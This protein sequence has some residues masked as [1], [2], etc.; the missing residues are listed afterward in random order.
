MINAKISFW[1]A[2]FFEIVIECAYFSFEYSNIAFDLDELLFCPLR[3]LI[4][5]L[6][7]GSWYFSYLVQ[8]IW[9]FLKLVVRNCRLWPRLCPNTVHFNR[10]IAEI[11]LELISFLWILIYLCVKAVRQLYHRLFSP[12]LK[13]LN[14]WVKFSIGLSVLCFYLLSDSL[15]IKD[16]QSQHLYLVFTLLLL[17][18]SLFLLIA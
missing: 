16:N 10:Q 17:T 5:F 3:L 4:E 1:V 18:T 14:L 15:D 7:S 13:F 12:F 9:H 11:I 8:L 6:L 2:K